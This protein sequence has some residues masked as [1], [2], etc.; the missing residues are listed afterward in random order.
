MQK[1]KI[2]IVG[3]DAKIAKKTTNKRAKNIYKV[4][5]LALEM[6]ELLV[7]PDDFEFIEPLATKRSEIMR[8]CET[9]LGTLGFTAT[10]IGLKKN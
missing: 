6:T 5:L 4:W 9:E 3:H 8:G 7:D 1:N 10:I 2:G